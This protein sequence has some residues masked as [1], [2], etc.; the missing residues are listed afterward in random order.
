MFTESQKPMLERYLRTKR[1]D[2]REGILDGH[3]SPNGWEYCCNACGVRA[4]A[5][6]DK[7]K[8]ASAVSDGRALCSSCAVREL[9]SIPPDLALLLGKIFHGIFR[10][11]GSKNYFAVPCICG[12]CKEWLV[13]SAYNRKISA[14]LIRAPEETT[15]LVFENQPDAPDSCLMASDSKTASCISIEKSSLPRILA[16]TSDGATAET[17]ISAISGGNPISVPLHSRYPRITFEEKFKYF[18]VVSHLGR[19]LEHA[20]DPVAPGAS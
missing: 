11:A 3:M 4:Y 14:A 7:Y 2:V 6:Y 12:E 18:C 9:R 20:K 1:L 5:P 15:C 13:R 17:V 19:V 10:V 8:L 16:I